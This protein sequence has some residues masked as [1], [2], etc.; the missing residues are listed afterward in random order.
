MSWL[1]NINV[2]SL[3]KICKKGPMIARDASYIYIGTKLWNSFLAESK[4]VSSL[5]IYTYN[6]FEIFNDEEEIIVF[7][8]FS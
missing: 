4:Q 1:C 5:Y 6:N 2:S 3:H 8:E 7:S